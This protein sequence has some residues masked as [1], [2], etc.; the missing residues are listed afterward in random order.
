MLWLPPFDM[1]NVA[2]VAALPQELTPLGITTFR[3]TLSLYC[4]DPGMTVNAGVTTRL[5]TVTVL[6]QVFVFPDPSVT[7][8]R[9]VDVPMPKTYEPMFPVPEASTILFLVIVQL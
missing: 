3:C 9:I 6:L 4:C 5:F 2:E 7:V 1:V 8:Y